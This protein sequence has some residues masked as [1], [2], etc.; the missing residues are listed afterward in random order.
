MPENRNS[1]RAGRRFESLA[2]LLLCRAL[3]YF[4]CSLG[5][6]AGGVGLDG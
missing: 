3:G 4:F 6:A 1:G 5:V 2:V